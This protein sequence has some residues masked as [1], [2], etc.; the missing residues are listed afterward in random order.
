[1]SKMLNQQLTLIKHVQL[2]SSEGMS[3]SIESAKLQLQIHKQDY[4]EVKDS[5][6]QAAKE[7][8]HNPL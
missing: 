8:E 2:I 3:S 6:A 5:M 7:I 1:M 4:V